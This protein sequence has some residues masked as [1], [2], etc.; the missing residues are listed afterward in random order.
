MADANTRKRAYAAE[1][2]DYQ[3]FKRMATPDELAQHKEAKKQSRKAQ[4]DYRAAVMATKTSNVTGT[5]SKDVG[6]KTVK[7]KS[8]RYLNFW[9]LVEAE[10]G[11]VNREFGI[12][13]ATNIATACEKKGPPLIMWDST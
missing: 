7:L 6:E 8:G 13:V 9:K 5:I 2:A 10:G 11:L 3:R 4:A 12:E 1:E